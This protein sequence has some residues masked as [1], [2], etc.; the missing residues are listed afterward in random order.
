M[1]LKKL[2][3]L[4]ALVPQIALAQ[5]VPGAPIAV[6]TGVV[7][8]I[9]RIVAGIVN[10][11][12]FWGGGVTTT[13]FLVGAFMMVGSGGG[14]FLENGKKL[15]IGAAVGYAIILSAW[16]IESTVVFFIAG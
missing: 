11:L 9:P 16:L 13:I 12:L 5:Y 7:T 2:L 3:Y 1:S 4:L 8:T 14:R 10:V 6:R 15:M